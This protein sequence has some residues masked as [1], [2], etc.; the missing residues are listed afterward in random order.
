MA[1][2]RRV[3]SAV[4]ASSCLLPA[5]VHRVDLRAPRVLGLAPFGV[6]PAGA[7]EPLQRRQ[8]RS[9]VD[10]EDAARDL[11]DTPRDAEAVHR[12]EA[13]RLEDEQVERA[14]ND[15]GVGFV[16]A[17]TV[18]SLTMI[19]KICQSI[20]SGVGRAAR[21]R[22]AEERSGAQGPRERRSRGLGR[23]PS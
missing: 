8:Q 1:A 18:S 15:V 22:A 5:R 14:L 17:E 13:E 2:A 6:E 11:L 23:S 16:H 10:L 9:G 19:V 7:L 20:G 4:A 3:Q 21:E 12:L